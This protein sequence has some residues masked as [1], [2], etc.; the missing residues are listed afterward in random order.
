MSAT[1][2]ELL[3]EHAASLG[4]KVFVKAPGGGASASY[5]A[6]DRLA[7]VFA[8]A[9]RRRGCRPGDRIFLTFGNTSDFFVALFGAWRAGL[10]AAPVDA[11]LAR[12][13]LG[14]LSRHAEPTAVLAEETS[15]A[16][17]R[18][19]LG[20]APVWTVE[21]LVADAEPAGDDD[22]HGDGDPRGDDAALL[23]YT[24]GTTG[25]PKGVLLSHGQL[26]AK[27]ETLASWLG[28]DASRTALC[29]LPTHFGHGLICN[30]L[31]VLRYGGTLVVTPPFHL[32]LVKELWTIV[33]ENN[34]HTF[35]SV[36]TVI[37][38]LL[39]DAERRGV[40]AAPGSLEFITCASAPLWPEEIAA[41]EERFGVPVLNCYG[42]T[43][44]SGWSACSPRSAER[45]PASVGKAVGCE[46]RA[47]GP[48]GEALPPGETGELQILGPSVMSGYY[49]SPE[50]TREVLRDGW[51]ATGDV[52]RV[53]KAGAVFLSS[54]KKEII[55]RAGKNVFPAEIDEILSSHPEILEAYAVGLEDPLLGEKVAACAVRR[56]GSELGEGE[57][58][59]YARERLAAYKCPQRIGF[60][61]SIPKSSRGK[62]SRAALRSFFGA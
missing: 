52:W 43:E 2:D 45:D 30:C 34:V 23:L 60:V 11:D 24:S 55:I 15:R 48:D 29:L 26:L 8:A 33:A 57:L 62:V 50:A 61:K 10:V 25:R 39:K 1:L 38:L 18:E 7:S 14:T 27:V 5:G 28:F 37:R 54:R 19:A 51:L 3:R 46:I 56:E 36:P 21:E 20:P 12:D 17:L 13:E 6:L 32:E 53:D 42:L 22:P 44:T 41:F 9:L 35:S 16:K 4:D 58:I 49:K 59:A 47:A 31:P 40:S